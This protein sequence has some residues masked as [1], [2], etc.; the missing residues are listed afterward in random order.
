MFWAFKTFFRFIL[1]LPMLVFFPFYL[2][3]YL[4]EGKPKRKTIKIKRKNDWIDRY[5]E[6]DVF[7]S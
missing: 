7:L 3:G 4:L 2:I 1:R 5:E 6:Y